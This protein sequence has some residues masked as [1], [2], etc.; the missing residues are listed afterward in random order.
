MN[1]LPFCIPYIGTTATVC[2]AHD[3]VILG[4]LIIDS[5]FV[6]SQCT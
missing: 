1:F 2:I 6:I 5:Y 4:D 3:C